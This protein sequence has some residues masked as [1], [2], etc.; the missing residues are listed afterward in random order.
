MEE[1][2]SA[3]KTDF[4]LKRKRIYFNL[5]LLYSLLPGIYK[6]LDN[7]LI[8]LGSIPILLLV[9]IDI[10]HEVKLYRYDSFFLLFLSYI[11][12][13]SFFLFFFPFTNKVGMAMGI[14]MNFFPMV[15]YFVGRSIKFENFSKMLLKIVLIHC[16]LGIILYPPFRITNLY[17][18][19]VSALKEGVAVSRMSSVSGSL[20]FGNLLMIGFIISIFS[21]KKYL[22]FMIIGLFFSSQRSAWLGGIFGL[23]LYFIYLFRNKKITSLLL[24][25]CIIAVFCISTVIIVERNSQIDLTYSISRIES[26]KD[27]SDE[28]INQWE[29]GV[30]NFIKYPIGVGVGQAGQFAA[31]YDSAESNFKA[32]PDGDYLRSLSE[33]GFAGGLFFLYIITTFIFS[34]IFLPFKDKDFITLFALMGGQLIQMIGSNISEFY[35]T[36]FIFWIIIGYYCTLI[37]KRYTFNLNK[38]T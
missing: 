6:I 13:Q 10:R 26:I 28:R 31:R 24:T 33:Y 32:I 17:M 7:Q 18:P 4:D 23:L 29:N 38:T 19:I 36:N 34:F 25:F 5:L 27:A 14:Y 12:I 8:M 37:G 16:I 3:N 9:V 15:G 20:G 22:P 21:N 35:F 11:L 2:I 30:S 1:Q